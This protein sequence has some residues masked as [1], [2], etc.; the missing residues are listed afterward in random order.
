MDNHNNQTEQPSESLSVAGASSESGTDSSPSVMPSSPQPPQKSK[1]GLVIGLVTALLLV[2]VVVACFV[3]FTTKSDD[4]PNEVSQDF[5]KQTDNGG[6]AE[7]PELKTSI[8]TTGF[9][10]KSTV[11]IEHPA[12]WTVKS[13]EEEY[14]ED[15]TLN[16]MVIGSPAGHYLHIYDL[17]GVGG[18]CD[19]NTD[20]FTLVKRLPIKANGYTFDEYDVPNLANSG[21]K[22]TLSYT[23]GDA[24][25][26]AMQEGDTL[27]NTCNMPTYSSFSA[28]S[29]FVSINNS[30]S[31]ESIFET[32]VGWEAIKDDAEFVKM[33]ESIEYSDRRTRQQ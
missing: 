9:L 22:L 25:V 13:G 19:D 23:G 15:T 26:A 32:R 18:T 1:K 17:D 5:S 6:S 31:R 33:L 3:L 24:A 2:A 4:Q 10:D 21:G 11:S 29:I 28:S 8:F 30:D 16:Y 14:T 12:D 20:S 7:Q 27:T